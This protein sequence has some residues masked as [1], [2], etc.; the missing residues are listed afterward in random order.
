[1]GSIVDNL[2]EH[3][4]RNT[5]KSYPLDAKLA[6][7]SKLNLSNVYDFNFVLPLLSYL[8]APE[9]SVQTY[10]FCRSGA[11]SL[12]IAALSSDVEETRAAACYVLYRFY[13]HLE[14]KQGGKDKLIYLR[15]IDAI[16]KGT[17]VLKDCKMNNFASI[18]FSRMAQILTHPLHTMY[19]PLSQYLSAKAIPNISGIPELYTF[20]HSSDVNYKE[21]RHFILEVIRDGLRTDSDL[22]VALKTMTF[23]LILE[24]YNSCVCDID[25]K[26]LVLEILKKACMTNKGVKYLCNV[27]GLMTFL[28]H[29]VL[30][31]NENRLIP[32]I[33]DLLYCIIKRD[34]K[35]FDCFVFSAIVSHLID[36]YC[37][38]VKD[39]PQ[40]IEM[41]YLLFCKHM[42]FLNGKRFKM[43]L[44]ITKSTDAEYLL[45]YGHKGINN[46]FLNDIN[47]DDYYIKLLTIKYVETVR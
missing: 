30:H 20:L 12:T 18:F 21:H 2:Q 34:D 32:S 13:H 19:V 42:A 28:H 33:I 5:A 16:C 35:Y 36:N 8:L 46:F 1:M 44:S 29:T 37:N 6:P 38:F 9:N 31:T 25:S 15:L 23:K 7:D 26:V 45:R 41:I 10:R 4:I 22:K 27:H 43:V 24:M 47:A 40:F 11:L 39:V 14:A 3:W 17:A